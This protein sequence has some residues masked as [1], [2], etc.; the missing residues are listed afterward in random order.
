MLFSGL[1]IAVYFVCSRQTFR[2]RSLSFPNI[3]V[4]AAVVTCCKPVPNARFDWWGRNELFVTAEA[5]KVIWPA[6]SARHHGLVRI[7]LLYWFWRVARSCLCPCLWQTASIAIFQQERGTGSQQSDGQGGKSRRLVSLNLQA[8]WE[9]L[10]MGRV[11]DVLFELF[12]KVC[13]YC[14]PE[15]CT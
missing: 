9:H 15:Q 2:R 12:F 6:V 4:S 10:F 5:I 3:P 8:R 7:V 1:E 11:W 14:V 13:F